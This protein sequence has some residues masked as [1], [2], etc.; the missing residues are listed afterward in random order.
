M[1]ENK[2]KS[3]NIVFKRYLSSYFLLDPQPSNGLT[4]FGVHFHVP[5][6]RLFRMTD[7]TQYL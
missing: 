1:S 4:V 7:C 2:S 6:H 3:L 5:M